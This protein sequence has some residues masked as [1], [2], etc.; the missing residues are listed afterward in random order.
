[1]TSSGTPSVLTTEECQAFGPALASAA[2]ED[3]TVYHLLL[4]RLIDANH[5]DLTDLRRAAKL[6]DWAGVHRS[7][8]R[9]KGSA[10]LAR[11]PTLVAAGKSIESAAKYRKA[12]VVN[13]LLPRYVAIVT[14]FND[15][16]RDLRSNRRSAPGGGYVQG[17]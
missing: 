9:L 6:R 17:I 15:R 12:A 5:G 4:T 2:R 11:C 14:E 8:H 10:A 3:P 1:M 7:I 13:A 16:L